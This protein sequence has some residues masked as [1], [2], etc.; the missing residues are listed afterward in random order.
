MLDELV[1]ELE[2]RKRLLFAAACQEDVFS[3]VSSPEQAVI[4]D[5][6]NS[7]A[8]VVMLPLTTQN[9]TIFSLRTTLKVQL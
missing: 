8:D 7:R 4:A 9:R 6:A 1:E 3:A 5:G 2:R